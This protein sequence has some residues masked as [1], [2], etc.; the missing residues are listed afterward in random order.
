MF[1]NRSSTSTSTSTFICI[2]NWM[3]MTNER[4]KVITA[5]GYTISEKGFEPL[6]F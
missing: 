4:V 3:K 1:V 5:S 6:F 2:S